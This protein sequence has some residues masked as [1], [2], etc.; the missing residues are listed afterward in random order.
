MHTFGGGTLK[1][2][3]GTQE[4]STGRYLG[5]DAVK[6]AAVG[7]AFNRPYISS[8]GFD[9]D[10]TSEESIL[11]R[12]ASTNKKVSQHGILVTEEYHVTRQ[13]LS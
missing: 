1:P 4:S 9:T 12:S 6:K 3:E 8:G 13:R 10:N 7:G 2:R 5:K 11:G